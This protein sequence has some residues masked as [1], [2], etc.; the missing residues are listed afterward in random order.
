M[1]TVTAA[2]AG[3]ASPNAACARCGGPFHCGANDAGPCACS[4]LV[5]PPALLHELQQRYRG[6]LCL[7]CLRALA[8]PEAPADPAP[9]TAVHRR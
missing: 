9:P 5:L 3:T 4:T 7:G 1:N 2:E 8:A 6:C